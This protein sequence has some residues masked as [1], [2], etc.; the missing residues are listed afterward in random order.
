M[1]GITRPRYFI[2]Y[3]LQHSHRI[4]AN[5]RCVMVSA[6]LTVS[7]VH[8]LFA[9][10]AV[11]LHYLSRCQDAVTAMHCNDLFRYLTDSLQPVSPFYC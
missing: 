7:L 6:M 9:Q 5:F 1:S 2:H 4:K 3:R 11:K 10:A 8:V